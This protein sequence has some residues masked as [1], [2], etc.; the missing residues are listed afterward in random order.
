MKKR[1]RAA[2]RTSSLSETELLAQ[3]AA[4]E[5]VAAGRACMADDRKAH[6]QR[7]IFFTEVLGGLDRAGLSPALPNAGNAGLGGALNLAF[8]PDPLR[9]LPMTVPL[10][11]SPGTRAAP[12]HPSAG[13]GQEP[14]CTDDWNSAEDR[15]PA[16]RSV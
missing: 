3:W 1:K 4:E 5:F 11:H 16:S 14:R 15:Q 6:R 8:R 9:S 10:D 12:V 7:A 2:I 13:A